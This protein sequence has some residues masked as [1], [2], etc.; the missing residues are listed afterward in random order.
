MTARIERG[1]WSVC[2]ET[3]E[4]LL[5]GL[6]ALQQF[7]D[8]SPNTPPRGRGRPLGPTDNARVAAQRKL[9]GH[10]ERALT[11]LRAIPAAPER[12]SSPELANALGLPQ[13]H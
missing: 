7:L 11:F 3:Q 4:E 5:V 12:I 6:T 8:N 13:A 1:D 2:G 10:K 9:E